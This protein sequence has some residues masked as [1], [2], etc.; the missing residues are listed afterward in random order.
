M[1]RWQPRTSPRLKR[2]HAWLALCTWAWLATF[3]GA[4]HARP[5]EGL[6]LHTLGAI[7]LH[8]EPN[9]EGEAQALLPMLPELWWQVEQVFAVEL[10]D[11]LDITLVKH[12][13]TVAQASGMP[14]TVAGV[15]QP[16]KGTLMVALHGPDGRPTSLPSLV[17][18]EMGHVALHRATAGAALPRWFHEGVAEAVEGTAN[19]GRLEDLARAYYGPGV[20]AL[21]ELSDTIRSDDAHDVARGYAT[22]RDFGLYARGGERA[23]AFRQLMTRLRE[24]DDFESAIAAAYGQPL[25][26]L[27][28]AWRA[29][30]R[31]RLLYY[32][33]LGGGL[34][35]GALMLPLVWLAWRRKRKH[36]HQGLE[37]LR[38]VERYE[39]QQALARALLPARPGHPCTLAC[40]GTRS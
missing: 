32:P 16:A 29:D 2:A 1:N 25:A 39:Q 8:A 19:L 11:T 20:P 38:A 27:E 6:D 15:A 7:R 26:E 22:A 3:A 37:R 34:L 9:L 12:A 40:A 35:P 28:T 23:L 36:Y 30:M 31:A 14:D 4:A 24:G 33:F 10:E 5:L 17:R 18:H 21:A 13:S